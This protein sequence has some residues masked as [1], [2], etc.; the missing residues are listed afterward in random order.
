MDDIEAEV[1]VFMPFDH[2]HE[3]AERVGLRNRA[4]EAVHHPQMKGD[5]IGVVVNK[6]PLGQEVIVR[7]HFVLGQPRNHFENCIF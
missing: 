7:L 4:Q 2:R 3:G 1:E 6:I 5:L